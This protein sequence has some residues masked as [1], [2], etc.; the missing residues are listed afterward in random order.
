MKAFVLVYT[1]IVLTAFVCAKVGK[2]RPKSKDV[3]LAQIQNMDCS[4]YLVMKQSGKKVDLDKS[5]VECFTEGLVYVDS[6]FVINDNTE[7]LFEVKLLATPKR[8]NLLEAKLVPT[9]K[10]NVSISSGSFL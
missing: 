7:H 3:F 8:T 9:P 2:K 4:L 6:A 1:A 5:K 10:G